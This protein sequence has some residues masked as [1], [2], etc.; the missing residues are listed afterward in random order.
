MAGTLDKDVYQS[1]RADLTRKAER[2]DADIAELEAKLHEAEVVQ[3]D[4]VQGALETLDKFSGAEE[5][6]QK[7]VQALIDKVVVF[8]QEHVEICWKF[9]DEVLKLIQE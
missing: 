7:I 2:L 4:D 3:D 9:S 8:D 5:L 6:D 1:R